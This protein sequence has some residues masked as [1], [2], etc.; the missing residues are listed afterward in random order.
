MDLVA[1][2]GGGGSGGGNGGGADDN[3]Y[4]SVDDTSGISAS[5][6]ADSELPDKERIQNLLDTLC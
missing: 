6:H 5:V 4:E 2:D 3:N 1:R